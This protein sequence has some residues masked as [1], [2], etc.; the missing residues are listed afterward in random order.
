[1]TLPFEEGL[2][3]AK[4]IFLGEAPAKTE[5]RLGRPL[6]GPSGDVFNECLHAAGA[7]RAEAYILNVWE[8]PVWK[9]KRGLTE[10][11]Y[12]YDSPRGPD[13]LLWRTGSGFTELGL[14]LA[15]RT[16]TR[17][18]RSKANLIVPLGQQAMELCTGKTKGILKW[19]GSI[20]EGHPRVGKKIIPTLHPAATIHG[21]YL[22]RYLIIADIEKAM[23]E[24][25]Y[26]D[27]RL[28]DRNLIIDPKLPDI[29]EYIAE[30]RKVGKFA[31]D[32]EVFNH[33]VCCFSLSHDP[34]EAMSIPIFDE[35]GRSIFSERQ[36][37]AIWLAYAGAMEDPE[38]EK[39]NQNLIG[40]DAPFLM[41]QNNIMPAGRMWDTQIAQ[42]VLYPEFRKGLDFI[43]SIHTREPYYKEEGKMW[44]TMEGGFDNFL[45]YNA[46]DSCVALE[47]WD[48]LADEMTQD[49]Y[50][51]T[52][53]LH[54][55]E[56]KWLWYIVLR[57][58]AVN[59]ERL[60]EVKA[61]VHGEMKAKYA[62]LT[63]T[64]EWDF[65]P[66]S[67]KQ[68][69]KYFYIT[70][71]L[72]PYK[73]KT[74]GITTDDGAMARIY[75]RYGLKEA[76]LVQEIRALRKLY[77]TYMEVELDPDGRLRCSYDPRGTWTGRISSSA[78]IFGRG[79][80]MLNLHPE[81]K[82][83]LVADTEALNA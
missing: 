6:C 40:F 25:E 44:K 38:V 30:C 4:I 31:T 36:E 54:E 42:S 26:P 22:W 14:E 78:T 65:N 61:R 59:R 48:V 62:E 3:S 16:L 50:W 39:V 79:M 7:L 12:E 35:T 37:L 49:E 1:M 58:F 11:F 24:Q 27:L 53:F 71:G 13:N 47:S 56:K 41:L 52:Y 8:E 33:H 68:C 69:Q 20:L 77:S 28:P 76:K 32:L 57:G 81:F 60:L 18:K 45:R 34:L 10:Y 55:E 19:R 72:A 21:I 9:A 29:L 46:K 66:Q 75:R 2:P 17:I 51:P 83:F 74:G 64:A 23:V 63:A 15:Q 43:T 67:P 80:N 5:M 73:G 82:E 70:K